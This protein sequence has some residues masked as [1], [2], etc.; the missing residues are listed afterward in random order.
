MK[1]IVQHEYGAPDVLA[2]GEVDK[3]TI[4][5]DEVLVEV[6]REGPPPAN[7]RFIADAT[8]NVILEI[9]NNPPDAVPDYGA[10]DPLLFHVAFAV[11][12]LVS[13]RD[14]LAA[15]GATFVEEFSSPEGDAFVMLRDPWGFPIQLCKR[16]EAMI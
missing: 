10:M 2:L 7:A 8:G 12:D 4:G 9:Y 1:A 11:D 16:A 14:E 5:D 3:P 6:V 15:A 13:V